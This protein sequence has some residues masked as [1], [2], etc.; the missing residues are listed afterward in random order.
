M[1]KINKKVKRKEREEKIDF[2]HPP[3]WDNED[4]VIVPRRGFLMNNNR[5]KKIRKKSFEE[6]SKRLL[7]KIIKEKPEW[8]VP[9]EKLMENDVYNDC[10]LMAKNDSYEIIWDTMRPLI[11]CS[12][13]SETSFIVLKKLW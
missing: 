4:Y 6:N 8:Y 1:D 2:I 10:K 13:T 9:D 3:G 5:F 11:V 12:K 7:S